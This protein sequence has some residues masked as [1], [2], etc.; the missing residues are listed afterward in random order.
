M[1]NTAD[2]KLC[3][4][5]SAFKNEATQIYDSFVDPIKKS[6]VPSMIYHYTD[7]AGLRGI[8][9]SGQLWFTDI[10]KL[11]DPTELKHGVKYAIEI[12]NSRLSTASCGAM[13]L[14]Y[15]TDRFKEFLPIH[16]EESADYF[17]CCFS[18]ASDDLGQWRAYADNGRGYSLGFDGKMFSEAFDEVAKENTST[19]SVMYN[20]ETLREKL[21]MLIDK[22]IPILTP[23]NNFPRVPEGW[24]EFMINV[25]TELTIYCILLS[26]LFKHEAYSQER[27]YRFVQ[28]YSAD[29]PAKNLKFRSRP[30]SLIKYIE[31]DWKSV[32]PKSL[33]EIMI[34][35]AADEMVARRFAEDCISAYLS[36]ATGT[37]KIDKSPLPYRSTF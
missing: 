18:K 12:L 3:E 2:D 23:D 28:I 15:F 24:K 1:T 19:F 31:L 8:L 11:N 7:D 35:P 22:V 34:G 33:K 5:L 29:E 9:E 13:V 14:N 21:E 4:L 26:H 37:I 30:Y 16:I 20:D 6:Q 36:A 32:A 27:E 25:S 17:V 10:F